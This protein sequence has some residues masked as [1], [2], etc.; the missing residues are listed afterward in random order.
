[1]FAGIREAWGDRRVLMLDQEGQ[2]HSLP[3]GWTDAAEPDVFVTISA[4]RSA[5][6]VADLVELATM[7]E[8]LQSGQLG[9]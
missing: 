9:L 4:G 1:V 7:L 5:F 3:V 8:G 2:L 6:K